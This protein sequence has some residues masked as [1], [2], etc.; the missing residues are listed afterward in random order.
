MGILSDALE[1]HKK[2]RET[3]AE[4][5]LTQKPPGVREKSYVLNVNKDLI[6]QYGYDP[7]LLVITAPDSNEAEKFRALRAQVLFAIHRKRPGIIMVTSAAKGDGK[8]FVAA[9]L[10]VSIALGIDENVLLVDCNLRQPDIHN[11]FGLS[12]SVGLRE[13]LAGKRQLSDLLITTEINKLSLLPAGHPPHNPSML[14]ASGA[15]KSFLEEI[16]DRYNDRIII[17]DTPPSQVLAEASLI[18]NFVEGII[19]VIRAEKTPTEMIHKAIDALER[20][21]IL[22]IVFNGVR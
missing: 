10:A 9:N 14:L 21:K 19:F 17:L 11:M 16:R 3:K 8:T 7:R 4:E 15:M 20:D 1:K 5:V 12:S 13:Y 2:E 22:G 18:A 6:A